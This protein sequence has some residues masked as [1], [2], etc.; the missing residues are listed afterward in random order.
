MS[1]T[2]YYEQDRCSFFIHYL[3][4]IRNEQSNNIT[5]FF[6]I[7]LIYLKF[8]DTYNLQIYLIID[9]NN[10][11]ILSLFLLLSKKSSHLISNND[12][13]KYENLTLIQKHILRI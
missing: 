9:A 12:D 6:R 1:C 5:N 3:H 13:F 11:T 4:E 2:Y 10:F 7:R 8:F